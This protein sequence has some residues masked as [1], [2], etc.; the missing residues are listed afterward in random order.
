[1]LGGISPI[2]EAGREGQFSINFAGFPWAL[3]ACRTPRDA[4]K[5][6]GGPTQG[7]A[8]Q[9]SKRPSS[10]E[11]KSPRIRVHNLSTGRA[12]TTTCTNTAMNIHFLSRAC[13]LVT[14]EC[15]RPLGVWMLMVKRTPAQPTNAISLL[16][17]EL[18]M[19]EERLGKHRSFPGAL[20][21]HSPC[22]LQEPMG[23]PQG[24]TIT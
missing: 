2:N 17:G 8:M 15:S 14:E 20:K 21:Q 16:S 6:S 7:L 13:T 3:V 9:I 10:A 1:M 23:T 11:H 5:S 19:V 18:L 4:Q 24:H 22:L 12:M